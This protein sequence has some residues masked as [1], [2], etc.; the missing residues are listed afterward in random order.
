MDITEARQLLGVSEYAD[1]DQIF[2]ANDVIIE[3]AMRSGD[4]ALFRQSARAVAELLVEG[5]RFQRSD[6]TKFIQEHDDWITSVGASLDQNLEAIRQIPQRMQIARQDLAEALEEQAAAAANLVAAEEAF[7]VAQAD[8][9]KAQSVLV[10]QEAERKAKH[11]ARIQ[12]VKNMFAFL[13]RK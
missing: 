4:L 7:S 3:R 10:A 8:Y 12:R 2:K 5:G 13:T 9:E 6:A 11:D 1:L